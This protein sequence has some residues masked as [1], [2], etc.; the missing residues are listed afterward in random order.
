MG[1]GGRRHSLA[2]PSQLGDL[3]QR[4]REPEDL[5]RAIRLTETEPSML[6]ASAHVL[7]VAYRT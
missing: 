2:Q 7:G 3:P 1:G 5:L 6:G 4:L